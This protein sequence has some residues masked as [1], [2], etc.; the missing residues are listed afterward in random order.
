MCVLPGKT[1]LSEVWEGPGSLLLRVM[2]LDRYFCGIDC[3]TFG[4]CWHL[5]SP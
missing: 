5:E 4:M 1:M 3:G 2:L